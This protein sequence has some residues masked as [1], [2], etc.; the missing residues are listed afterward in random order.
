M[1][2]VVFFEKFG[3]NTAINRNNCN[4]IVAQVSVKWTKLSVMLIWQGKGNYTCENK[5]LNS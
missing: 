1:A 2:Y 5:F 3:V 4:K